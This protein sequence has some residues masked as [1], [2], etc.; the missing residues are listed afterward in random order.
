MSFRDRVQVYKDEST[1]G[2]GTAGDAEPFPTT[3]NPSQDAL[4]CAGLVINDWNSGTPVRDTNV[5]VERVGNDMTFKDVTN[6]TKTLAQLLAPLDFTNYIFS[7]EGGFVYT[8]DMVPV[9]RA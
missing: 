1:A 7:N 3:L 5:T 9:T 6:G 4:E 8:G 2:G